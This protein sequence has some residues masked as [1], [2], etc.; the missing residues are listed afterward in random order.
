LLLAF[1]SNR[2]PELAGISGRTSNIFN[3][4]QV[5]GL[6]SARFDFDFADVFKMEKK[7]KNFY[8]QFQF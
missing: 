6:L 4:L 3:F 1:S 5:G 7:I 8:L 2:S